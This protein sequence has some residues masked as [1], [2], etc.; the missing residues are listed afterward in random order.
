MMPV[1]WCLSY[2]AWVM[3]PGLWC[4]SYVAWVMMPELWCCSYVAWV[5]MPELWCLSYYTWV[6]MSELWCLRY[7]AVVMMPEL[8]CLSYDAWV[9]MP[10][11]KS[12]RALPV[13]SLVIK[14]PSILVRL[15]KWPKGF[16]GL[17]RMFCVAVGILRKEAWLISLLHW[18][19]GVM[20]TSMT[21]EIK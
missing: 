4:L 2:D 20:W 19:S 7:D 17:N 3:I 13:S 6:M 21:T 8:L 16:P 14:R 15:L 18:R 1:L 11:L 10:E 9:M 5:M 12:W